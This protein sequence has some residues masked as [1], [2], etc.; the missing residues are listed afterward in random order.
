MRQ[1]RVVE[2]LDY[3]GYTRYAVQRKWLCFWK[4]ADFYYDWNGNSHFN[5]HSQKDGAIKTVHELVRKDQEALALK[6]KRAAHKNKVVY[7]PY[8][9]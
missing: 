6:N 8:P 3:N 4:H 1:Y 7:G 5:Y 9:P 2:V